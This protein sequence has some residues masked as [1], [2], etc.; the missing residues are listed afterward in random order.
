MILDTLSDQQKDAVTKDGNV[1]LTACPGSGKTRV[2]IHKL[3]YAL[4][5]IDINSKQRIVALT[6]TVRA[7]EEIYRRLNAMGINSNRVWSGTL[8]SF[9]LEWIIKPYSCYLPELVNGYL[10]ADETYASDIIDELKEKHKLK[11]IDPINFRFN[12]DG[13]LAEPKSIQKRV[14]KEYHERLQAEKLIDFELLLFYSYKLLI[15][16]PKIKKTLS[17]IFSLICVDEY[18]DT[19]DLLY[20]IISS[21][22][23]TGEGNSNLFLVGDTDQAIYASLGGVAKSLEEIQEEL[24]TLPIE[25]LTLSGNYRST[26]RIIDFYSIFQTNPIKIEAIGTNKDANSIITYNNT[27]NKGYLVD[28]IARL[29][30]YSLNNGIPEDEICVLV[31]QWWLITTITKQLR[32]KLPKVNFDASGL[33]PMSKNRN[34]IWYKL[35]RLFLTEPKPKIYSLRYKWCSEVIE[36]F[37]EHTNTEFSEQYRTER[38]VLKLINSIMSNETEGIDYLNDCFDQFLEAV[39]IDQTIYT[40]L[41]INR[42]TFFDVIKSRLED[43]D[44]QVPSDIASFKGFYR[45]MSGVVINTCVGVKGEEFETVIAYGLLNGYVPHWNDIFN[46]D[47]VAASKKLLYVICSRAKTN[48]H[49]ISETGRQTAK[50]NQLVITPELQNLNFKF[51]KL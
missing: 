39:E 11:P 1:L 37:K 16:H 6:F 12:R 36:N 3:A 5:N 17:N 23:T 13:T 20:A 43:P 25:Q 47:P 26:Q 48:L 9:C 46:A 15:T 35:S 2:I 32:A 28:E 49:L 44:F 29:I 38:N 31:P 22:I 21:I 7:S 51:D 30:E 4:K 45:E 50:G 24:K 27:I 40:Q 18:Q 41:L 42:K 14:L 34:N 33:A 19:Q 10:I 8:H